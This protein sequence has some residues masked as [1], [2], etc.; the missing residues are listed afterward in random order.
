MSSAAAGKFQ[1]HYKV[2]GI[3]PKSDSTV[4]QAAY[5]KLAQHHHPKSG[6]AP[7]QEKFDALNL[8]FEV[9]SDPG[10]RSTFDSL[11]GG[12]EEA[13]VNF[14]GIAFF[15]AV[16]KEALIR[17]ALMC[18][19][20]DFRRLK[21]RTPGLSLRQIEPAILANYEE[22]QLAIWYL[23]TKGFIIMDDKSRLEITVAGMDDMLKNLPEPQ[24]VISMFKD[25]T[26]EEPATEAPAT[27]APATEAPA[28]EA[29]TTKA[30]TPQAPAQAVPAPAP[31]TPAPAPA[32][33]PAAPTPT[34]PATTPISLLSLNA[35][36]APIAPAATGPTH[37][38]EP[39]T[40]RLSTNLRRGPSSN[41]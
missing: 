1:D 11:R 39:L 2:L 3:D 31:A 7:D 18:L 22:L 17:N 5:S 25:I 41:G 10:L 20:Y 12:Q 36:T 34:P 35:A 32:P 19:L 16:K 6:I 4:I 27:E 8:A 28:T 21:P 24:S 37:P 15:D 14:S 40:L 33:E 38:A 30:A 26:P 13:P 23:K 9:L 29:P